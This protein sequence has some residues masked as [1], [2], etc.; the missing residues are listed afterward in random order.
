M[1]KIKYTKEQTMIYKSLQLNIE[2][3]EHPLNWNE[4]KC[5]WMARRFCS[6][7]M[8]LLNDTNIICYEY[9]VGHQ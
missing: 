6:T 7:V 3:H 8:W 9:R 4:L 5:S 2:Q 1:A